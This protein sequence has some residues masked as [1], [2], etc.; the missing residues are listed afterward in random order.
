MAKKRISKKKEVKENGKS[1]ISE[2]STEMKL[3]KDEFVAD[4]TK[5]AKKWQNE[6][7]EVPSEHVAPGD[8]QL[9]RSFWL[10]KEKLL[11]KEFERSEL[12]RDEQI[13]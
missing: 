6:P 1:P 10:Q 3:K 2:I 9:V 4:Y 13:E 7:Q 8:S 5:S 12:S 11:K